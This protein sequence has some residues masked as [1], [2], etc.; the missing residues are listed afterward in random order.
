MTVTLH[1]TTAVQLGIKQCM[2]PIMSP[3]NAAQPVAENTTNFTT[4]IATTIFDLH[5]EAVVAILDQLQ[6]LQRLTVAQ[7]LEAVPVH[8]D[9]D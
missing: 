4:K 7:Q 1:E 3:W 6:H 8:P 5:L 2:S 9:H